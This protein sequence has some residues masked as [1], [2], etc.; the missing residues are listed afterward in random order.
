MT[1]A[2]DLGD[3]RCFLYALCGLG[4]TRRQAGNSHAARD[5]FYR[6]LVIARELAEDMDQVQALRRLG[7][8]YS[9][10]APV[11]PARAWL[12]IRLPGWPKPYI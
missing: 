9:A 1:A 3:R 8:A 12:I 11:A 4:D 2:N 7:T 6:A 10:E 5:L